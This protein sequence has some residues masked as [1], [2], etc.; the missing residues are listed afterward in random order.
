MPRDLLQT[1]LALYELARLAILI[2][3]RFRGEY[4]AWRMHTAFGGGRPKSPWERL[5]SVLD[6]GRWVRRA[7]RVL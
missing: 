2:G 1:P 6:Y 7:R 5:R 4:W 3:L